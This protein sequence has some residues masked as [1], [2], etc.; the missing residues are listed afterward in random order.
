M[1]RKNFHPLIFLLPAVIALLACSLGNN[2]T[3]KVA[4]GVESAKETIAEKAEAGLDALGEQ[5]KIAVKDAVAKG[6]ESVDINKSF[7]LSVPITDSA[8]NNVIALKEKASQLTQTPQIIKNVRLAFSGGNVVVTGN[9]SETLLKQVNMQ[10]E[11][12][13]VFRPSVVDGKLQLSL[14]EARIGD[15]PAPQ[16]VFD[17][18]EQAQTIATDTLG[19]MVSAVKGDLETE[20]VDS[21]K[22]AV[23]SVNDIV[24]E[25]GKMTIKLTVNIP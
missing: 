25:E 16:A 12:R 15:T 24:I 4:S 6:L 5:A 9:P 17:A 21:Q 13:V 14:V 2:V 22:V 1:Y 18:V 8:V 7:N 3:D 10:G 23:V 19:E 11:M 20:M